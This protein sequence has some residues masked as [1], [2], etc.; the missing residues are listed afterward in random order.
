MIDEGVK[1]GPMIGKVS[2][3]SIGGEGSE[4]RLKN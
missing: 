1:K 3:E 2:G 4:K